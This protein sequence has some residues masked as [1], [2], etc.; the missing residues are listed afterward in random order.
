VGP[1]TNMSDFATNQELRRFKVN[2]VETLLFEMETWVKEPIN[3]DILLCLRRDGEV[4]IPNS[5]EFDYLIP[6]R[7]QE[8]NQCL[9][10]LAMGHVPRNVGLILLG[11][12]IEFN[13]RPAPV[14]E[15]RVRE[16]TTTIRTRTNVLDFGAAE[17]LLDSGVSL[18]EGFD[19]QICSIF[20]ELLSRQRI[21]R[22]N[23]ENEAHKPILAFCHS[24]MTVA[25]QVM[26][27]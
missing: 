20:I 15:H 6:G 25:P 11:I 10:I 8:C 22:S 14:L 23:V 26:P 5:I 27:D 12:P 19:W 4:S 21:S 16:I 18:R 7:S 1:R 24:P 9:A 13:F 17:V 3:R 2:L